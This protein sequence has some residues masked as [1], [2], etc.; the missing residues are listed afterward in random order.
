SSHDR[1]L[2]HLRRY[3]PSQIKSVL[4]QSCLHIRHHGAIFSSLLLVRIFEKMREALCPG[5]R[6]AKLEDW[7]A[8]KQWTAVVQ[9]LLQTDGRFGLLISKV[10]I[11]FLGLSWWA[12]CEK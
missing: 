4:E 12:L 11:D 1:A 2:S 7:K 3:S 6:P 9:R 5:Q 8:G 10:G